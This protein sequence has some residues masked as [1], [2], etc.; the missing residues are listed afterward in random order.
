M[1]AAAFRDLAPEEVAVHGGVVSCTIAG[2]GP[3]MIFLH[4]W[5]LDSR[6]WAPQVAAFA[7]GFRVIAPDR[8]GFGRSSAPPDLAREPDDIAR[9][10]DHVGA[11][12]AVVVGMS[13]AGRVALDFAAR[14]PDRVDALILQGAP[15]VGPGPHP[16]D[17]EAIPIAAWAALA[18]EGRLDAMKAQWRAHPLMRTAND[19]AAQTAEAMLRDYRGRDLVAAD[20]IA[21]DDLDIARIAAPALALTGARDT[22][23]RRAAAD[24]LAAGMPHARR[25]EIPD[26]GH[27]C[28]LC[29]PGVYNAV[30][31]T[32]LRE[33]CASSGPEPL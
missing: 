23:W 24:A 17:S 31:A 11:A 4:G 20:P 28:N 14:F 5:T 27:L 26:A 33:A 7:R 9:L 25:T 12:R 29:A 22:A 16:Q 8:R 13:Q 2:A 1:T 6:M 19:A 32:F 30:V 18:R 3:A 21:R 10:L 15:F